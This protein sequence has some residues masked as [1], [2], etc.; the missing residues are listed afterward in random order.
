[1]DVHELAAKVMFED[2]VEEE[3][4]SLALINIYTDGVDVQIYFEFEIFD[5][6][7][8]LD[9]E[10]LVDCFDILNHMA[11]LKGAFLFKKIKLPSL[12]RWMK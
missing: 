6:V 5:V 8:A 2:S 7:E 4:R 11:Y 9:R 10:M 12:P 3:I 1:M